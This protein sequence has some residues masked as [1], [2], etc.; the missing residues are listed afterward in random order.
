MTV[1][2]SEPIVLV[3]L[4]AYNG[5]QWVDEQVAS[6]LGQQGVQCR[7]LISDDGSTDGTRE[8]LH[9]WCARD[10]RVAISSA[11]TPS[12]S[13][14]ANF[15]NLFASAEVGDAT[16]IALCDQDDVWNE[17]KLL[18]ATCQIRDTGADLATASVLACWP[19][20]TRRVLSQSSVT[21]GADH[22]F[23]GAGQGCTYVLTLSLFASVQ[24]FV[25]LNRSQLVGIHY[26]DWLVYALSRVWGRSWVFDPVPCLVYR[27]HEQNDTGARG[28]LAAARKRLELIRSGWYSAQIREI[29]AVCNAA[30]PGNAETK[31]L[32]CLLATSRLSLA[33]R[34]RWGRYLLFESRRRWHD[35]VVLTICAALGYL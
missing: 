11:A 30:A 29:A 18:R 21:R 3:L 12:G 9:A 23:E 1:T 10:T 17:Q 4:A 15:I 24:A 5:V 7:L 13:A 34:F 28:G 32:R 16:H 27:Q 35:R 20:G 14:G 19:D 22:L 25:R 33:G 26:H 31:R 8:R 2:A 6:V